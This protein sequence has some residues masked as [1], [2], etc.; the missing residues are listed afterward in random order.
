MRIRTKIC[1]YCLKRPATVWSGHLLR[2]GK[3][4]TAGWCSRCPR[5]AQGF[6]GHWRKKMGTVKDTK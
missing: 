2:K 4:I 3:G 5:L 1:V 6:V